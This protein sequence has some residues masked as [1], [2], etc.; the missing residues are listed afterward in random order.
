MHFVIRFLVSKW[1]SSSSLVVKGPNATYNNKWGIEG[2]NPQYPNGPKSFKCRCLQKPV[3]C[4][5]IDAYDVSVYK[6]NQ[7]NN[8]YLSLS[9]QYWCVTTP[10]ELPRPN[11]P[12][13]TPLAPSF[14]TLCQKEWMW[15][16]LWRQSWRQ[17]SSTFSV[18]IL[19]LVRPLA[20]IGLMLRIQP[21]VNRQPSL[22]RPKL[23]K[24]NIWYLLMNWK[25]SNILIGLVLK[26]EQA[27]GQCDGSK[28][29]TEMFRTSH[30]NETGSIVSQ[31]TEKLIWW[32][33]CL[34]RLW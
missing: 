27:V 2:E 7:H 9:R 6:W 10:K 5:P 1:Y 14:L 15:T 11:A 31:V 25:C 26:I 16:S 3:D 24:V 17:S 28:A 34:C 4:K 19:G 20:M 32:L 13:P 29:R 30:Y 12:T 21:R 23:Q 18:L 22:W 33:T 8:E